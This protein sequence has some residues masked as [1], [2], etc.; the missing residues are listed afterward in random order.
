MKQAKWKGNDDENISLWKKKQNKQNCL[1]T[2]A[3][4]ISLEFLSC[5]MARKDFSQLSPTTF[6]LS[7]SFSFFF[8]NCCW[9]SAITRGMIIKRE[10]ER[11]T[12]EWVAVTFQFGLFVRLELVWQS[13]I[14][15]VFPAA[16]AFFV[17]TLYI[18]LAYIHL[19]ILFLFFLISS[20]MFSGVRQTCNCV[21]ALR[22]E[23]MG[24]D[25]KTCT[26]TR[27]KSR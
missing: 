15:D 8:S 17:W 7:L 18:C 6:I 26:N 22:V 2:R 27:N 13:I 12:S 25:E 23:M 19:L 5:F 20:V 21:C 9:R 1:L 11:E 14:V 3:D 4:R 16:A 24:N 10:R